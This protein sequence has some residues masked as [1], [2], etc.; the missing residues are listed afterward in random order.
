MNT[1][2]IIQGNFLAWVMYYK[3]D[4]DPAAALWRE[5]LTLLRNM[6]IAPASL[7]PTA[8]WSGGILPG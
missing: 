7:L 2:P 4:L 1:T 5:N 6:R 8:G 3:G